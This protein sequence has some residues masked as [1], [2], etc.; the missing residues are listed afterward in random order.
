MVTA[1]QEGPAFKTSL[2]TLLKPKA[3]PG[4]SVSLTCRLTLQ[5]AWNV[6][7]SISQ[8]LFLFSTQTRFQTLVSVHLLDRQRKPFLIKSTHH[9][10][11]TT[12][13]RPLRNQ[14]PP[15]RLPS[16]RARAQ[17]FSRSQSRCSRFIQRVDPS[18]SHPDSPAR[19]T[20]QCAGFRARNGRLRSEFCFSS[21]L[22]HHK[23]GV[24][25]RRVK[26]GNTATEMWV[27]CRT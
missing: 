17:A 21:V 23:I 3:E 8:S 25:S 4:V 16:E 27:F 11:Q 12:K 2:N 13:R 24:F 7:V 18:F 20:A 26:R 6:L 22:D 10:S 5:T 9:P 15:S 19:G 14:F 1:K